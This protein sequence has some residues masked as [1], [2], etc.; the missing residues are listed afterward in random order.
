MDRKEKHPLFFI[1]WDQFL[2]S[3]EKSQNPE[4]DE[5][6]E[7][8][9]IYLSENQTDK[10]R[11]TISRALIIYPDDEEM[12]YDILLLLNDFELWNDLLSLTER[13]EVSGD[14]WGDGHRL[15]AL[16]HLGMEEEAFLHFQ[17]MK[18]RYR[19]IQEDLLIIYQAMAE[20]LFEVDLFESAIDVI[21]EGIEK[22]G[23][24]SDFDW[25]L[26]QSHLAKGDRDKARKY[27]GKI[28]KENPLDP[29]T[30][31]RLGLA[32]SEMEEYESAIE[33]LENSRSLG[34]DPEQ[35]L[36]SLINAYEKN[37]NYNKVL[38][39]AKEY[40]NLQPDNY[41][42]LIIAAR[43]CHFMEKWDEALDFISKAIKLM[44]TMESLYLFKSSL[45]LRSGE[46]PQ[47]IRV[48]ECGIV[49]TNDPEGSLKEEL[50]RILDSQ[51]E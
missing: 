40:L 51:P 38:E 1:R 36:I 11:K 6:T 12:L 48:L 18:I 7:I 19:E 22:C 45:Y 33:A 32:Y 9:D 3:G 21:R 27:A 26:M 29:D 13:F 43:S 15:T 41:M 31:H 37:G 50:K 47:A 8:I 16:L 35:S 34:Y 28:E 39:N 30:W 2:D 24:N 44:P 42:I 49:A 25:I 14:V 23:E 5:L 17:K 4:P 46:I 10:A 20:A